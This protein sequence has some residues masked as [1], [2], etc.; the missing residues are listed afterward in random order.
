MVVTRRKGPKE[1]DR[2][3]ISDLLGLLA[4]GE[5]N[6]KNI[7]LLA[8]VGGLRSPLGE[9]PSPPG[10]AHRRPQGRGGGGWEET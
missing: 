9:V 1:E 4:K 6:S 10:P 7:E 5:M 8:S 3:L 2:E